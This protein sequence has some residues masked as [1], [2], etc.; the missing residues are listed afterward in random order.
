[1]RV[2]VVDDNAS[3]REILSTMAKSFGLEVDV[4]FDGS[5]ALQAIEEAEQKSI[6]YDLVLMD[7]KMPGMDGVEC[8][9]RLQVGGLAQVPAVIMVT[10]YGREEALSSAEERRVKLE[11]VLTKPV[12][13]ST[14][15]EAVGEALGKGVL[16]ETTKAKRHDAANESMK[17]LG[18]AKV[19]LVEDNEMNQELALELLRQAGMN[20]TLAE[21]G[22]IA[23]DILKDVT[24]FDGIL[25]DCQMPVMDGYKATRA[26][27][28]NPLFK[29]IPIIAMT[30]NA[31]VGDKEKAIEA[32]MVDH[33]AKPLNVNEMFNTIAKWI[34]PANPVEMVTVKEVAVEK[35]ETLPELLGIDTKA[36]LATTMNDMNLYKKLL[37]KFR[38]SQ[39][40]FAGQFAAALKDVNASTATRC[41]HT[42]KGTAGNIGA[43][44]VQA[45]AA[46]L[47]HAC[48]ESASKDAIDTL[49]T[50][51]LDALK[52]VL[53]GLQQLDG[54]EVTDKQAKGADPARVREL[55]EK[56]KSLLEDSGTY[57]GDVLEEL[58]ALTAGTPM[59]K[60]LRN[61]AAALAD[62]DFEMALARL[63]E[64]DDH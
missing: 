53:E 43:K 18:G 6:P 54:A 41:A 39:A 25:M 51:T 19:L 45:A 11:S 55:M 26:I 59:S 24:D 44:G 48:G 34:K 35:H 15:L 21:N 38:D 30:A 17:K 16:V 2:L 61:V 36:G 63:E 5:R 32:G 40:D 50:T 64:I 37:L 60:G 56:L 10:A 28:K 8:V 20:I 29:D 31:L 1:L 4:A 3:A 23:L 33:I 49:L 46:D 14:L 58:S 57:A 52:P 22:Q 13:P 47:E 7:W 27:R 42:L 12:T 9:H 62:Y